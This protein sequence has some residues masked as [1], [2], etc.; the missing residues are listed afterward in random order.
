VLISCY[1]GTALGKELRL[2]LVACGVHLCV[3]TGVVGPV[4][5]PTYMCVKPY[6]KYWACT[7]T[8]QCSV[9]RGGF[10][11]EA[12]QGTIWL[13]EILVLVGK[14]KLKFN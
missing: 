9:L 1:S 2:H 13:A 12:N 5:A 6:G 3:H 11:I 14:N 10:L 4:S 7:W 8:T